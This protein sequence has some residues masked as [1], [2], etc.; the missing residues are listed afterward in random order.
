MADQGKK[1]GFSM[2][3][4]GQ[5]T[6]TPKFATKPAPPKRLHFGDD[7][8]VDDEP[9]MEAVTGF[10]DNKVKRYVSIANVT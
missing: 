7:D 8:D 9:K 2:S 4:G 5:R 10:E 1:M 3:F 6:A